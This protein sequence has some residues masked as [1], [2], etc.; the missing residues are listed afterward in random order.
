MWTIERILYPT[1]FSEPAA[2]ALPHAVELARRFEAQLTVLHI[3]TLFQDDPS[4]PEYQFLNTGEYKEFL[5]EELKQV[6]RSIDDIR[7]DAR[8]EMNASAAAGIVDSAGEEDI[9]LIVMGTRGRSGLAHFFLGSVAE[10]VVRH[11]RCPVLTVD[12][13]H[14]F[15]G[16]APGYS[17]ILVAFDFSEH[18]RAALHHVETIRSR[19]DG[20]ITVVFVIEQ[21]LAPSFYTGWVQTVQHDIEEVTDQARRA[22]SEEVGEREADQIDLRVEVGTGDGRVAYEISRVASEID[23]DLVVAGSYGLSGVERFLLGS[24]TERLL[25][26]SPCP[27]LTFHK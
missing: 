11:A 21:Q 12:D 4:Q 8:L 27:V 7:L 2:H 1:D 24:T 14:E 10:K 19:Y 16:E 26:R 3:R 9:D 25:R 5:Q 15:E 6:A 18:S 17:N 23:A 20:R 22:L 13:E